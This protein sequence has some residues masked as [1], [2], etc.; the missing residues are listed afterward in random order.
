MA[1]LNGN[2]IMSIAVPK[3]HFI[4]KL[5]MGGDL[6]IIPKSIGEGLEYAYIPRKYIM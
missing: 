2:F 4:K 6:G 3:K 5:I 1:L